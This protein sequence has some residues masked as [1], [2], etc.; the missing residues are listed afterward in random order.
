[1]F[2]VGGLAMLFSL[3]RGTGAV[4]REAIAAFRAERYGVA[5]QGFSTVLEQEPGNVTAML[6]LG[7][8]YR[9]Q[10]RM[11]EAA[12][13]LSEAS[14]R[15]PRDPDAARELGH[16]FMDLRRPESAV[17]RFREAVE[18]DPADN[19]NW[20][21]LIQALR[22]AGDPSVDEWLQRAPAEVRAALTDAP[23]QPPYR[24]P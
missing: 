8:I 7:R 16:L 18:L 5:E 19:A 14:A 24:S 11:D 15:A 13:V 12:A 6:Y 23:P 4:E 2:L 9:V 22:A 17:P 1:V 10:G 21:A 20:I 3:L